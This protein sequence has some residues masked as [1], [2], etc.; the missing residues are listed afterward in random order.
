MILFDRPVYVVRPWSYVATGSCRVVPSIEFYWSAPS[1]CWS[2]TILSC[3]WFTNFLTL[4]LRSVKYYLSIQSSSK[5]T[6]GWSTSYSFVD[7]LFKFFSVLILYIIS[8]CV[9]VLLFLP[10]LLYLM[11]FG[12]NTGISISNIICS[13]LFL[14]F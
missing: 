10:L 5:F 14:V 9:L 7:H 2:F 4:L 3:N 6:W 8:L 13:L 12:Y 1:V 11:Y